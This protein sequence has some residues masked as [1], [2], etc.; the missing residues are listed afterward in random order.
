MKK[1]KLIV[2]SASGYCFTPIECKSIKEAIEEGKSSC[3]FAYRIF[4]TNG[5]LIKKGLCH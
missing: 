5:K 4:D 2:N 1:C 3:G